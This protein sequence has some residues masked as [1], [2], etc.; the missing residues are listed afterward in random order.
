MSISLTLIV[1]NSLFE[2]FKVRPETFLNWEIFFRVSTIGVISVPVNQFNSS[3][4]KN[5]GQLV[6]NY[7]C[8]KVI[9]LGGFWVSLAYSFLNGCII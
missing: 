9:A 8:C 1:K 4:A 3:S 6:V 7:C 2:R 5:M